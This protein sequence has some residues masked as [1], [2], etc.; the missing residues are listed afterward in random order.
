MGSTISTSEEREL[1][2]HLQGIEPASLAAVIWD[3]INCVGVDDEHAKFGIDF[4]GGKASSD[5]QKVLFWDTGD[6][7][8]MPRKVFLELLQL[9]S[10][11]IIED[12]ENK[13][14]LE[15]SHALQSAVNKLRLAKQHLQKEIGL[16]EGQ[17]DA[18][19]YRERLDSGICVEDEPTAKDVVEEVR[20][21]RGSWMWATGKHSFAYNG[22]QRRMSKGLEAVVD[23]MPKLRR[24]YETTTRGQG[25]TLRRV[26][27]KLLAF[28]SFAKLTG[29]AKSEGSLEEIEEDSPFKAGWRPV[30][31]ELSEPGALKRSP[32]LNSC[33]SVISTLGTPSSPG[34][35][36]TPPTSVCTLTPST[37][38][39]DEQYP[40]TDHPL[41]THL[42]KARETM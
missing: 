21:R 32:S 26:R 31:L 16:L 20:T 28:G 40:N 17:V 11:K 18:K 25:K 1:A 14:D 22:S 42:A 8:G 3:S 36:Y 33:S 2:T 13:Y 38:V 4:T 34:M 30:T 23:R 15:K 9:V 37:P 24:R 19:Q 29:G 27:N 5:S 10:E 6:A 12:Y 39:L 35:I 41:Q 7:T